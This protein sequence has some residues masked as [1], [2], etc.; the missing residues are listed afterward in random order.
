MNAAVAP[1]TEAGLVTH[2]TEL[3][4]VLA[5]LRRRGIAPLAACEQQARVY[6]LVLAVCSMICTLTLDPL[7]R[8]R[9]LS[10]RTRIWLNPGALKSKHRQL[11]LSTTTIAEVCKYRLLSCRCWWRW[12]YSSRAA[13]ESRRAWSL[14]TAPSCRCIGNGHNLCVGCPCILLVFKNKA[15]IRGSGKACSTSK[16]WPCVANLES[17][18]RSLLSQCRS[19][20]AGFVGGHRVADSGPGGRRAGG[21]RECEQQSGWRAAAARRPRGAPC[22]GRSRVAASIGRDQSPDVDAASGASTCCALTTIICSA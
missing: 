14:R 20:R 5:T 3:A 8:Q 4:A 11:Q 22:A 16:H 19:V 10:T 21:V 2:V 15:I 9:L 7:K 13:A 18:V 17:M 1:L 6:Q 12:R